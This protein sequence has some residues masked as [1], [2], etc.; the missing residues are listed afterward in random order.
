MNFNKGVAQG[1][2]SNIYKEVIP[3]LGATQANLI[4]ILRSIDCVKKS[5]HEESGRLDRRAFTRFATGSV[6]IFSRRE[7]GEADTSAVSVLIDC[8]LSMEWS[9]RSKYAEVVAIQLARILSKANVSYCVNGFTGDRQKNNIV[10]DGASKVSREYQV[11][12][13]Q[14]IPFKEWGESIHKAG[15]KLG[16][17]R[18]CPQGATPD[19]S[20]IIIKLE[21]L[22]GQQEKRKVMFLITDAD[23]YN[24]SHM[25]HIQAIAD[26]HKV[27]LIAIGLGSTGVDKVFKHGINVKDGSELGGVAFNKLLKELS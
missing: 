19:Y 3:N 16:T 20:S 17:I 8:S 27:T 21:E 12:N 5:S 11:E 9:S 22:I 2:F 4:R 24:V 25:E 1:N 10:A 14:F 18:E 23:G 26:K 7:V 13:V 6:A 15:P